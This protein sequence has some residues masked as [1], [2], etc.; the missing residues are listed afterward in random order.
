MMIKAIL[1]VYTEKKSL[2]PREIR[3]NKLYAFNTESDVEE[4]D[5]IN[6][7]SYNKPMLIVKVLPNISFK[8]YN[9]ANG[10]LSDYYSSTEQREVAN[11]V[12]REDNT[13]IVYGTLTKFEK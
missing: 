12:I 5:I 10:N 8:Y 9:R 7:E 2:T 13:D 6:S 3:A 1:V 11:L 4:G